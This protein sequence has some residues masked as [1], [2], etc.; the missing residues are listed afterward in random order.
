MVKDLIE[1]VPGFTSFSTIPQSGI[2]MVEERLHLKLAA[3][4][5]EIILEYGVVKSDK[6]VINGVG[7]CS[8]FNV[9]DQTIQQ[10]ILQNIPSD[11]YVI[12]TVEKSGVLVL[13]NASG[14]IFQYV[15]GEIKK[16]ADSIDDYV[17]KVYSFEEQ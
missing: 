5:K 3:D 2:D 12:E 1:K 4:Y 10:R 13:Q 16:Y 8:R 6:I 17:C 9:I 7:V 15:D 14:T 11:C